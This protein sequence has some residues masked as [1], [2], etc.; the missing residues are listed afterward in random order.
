[1]DGYRV[2]K[3]CL[4]HTN[5]ECR[6]IVSITKQIV[7]WMETYIA[8]DSHAF[9]P[10]S[11][12]FLTWGKIYIVVNQWVMD[13]YNLDRVNMHMPC[14]PSYALFSRAACSTVRTAEATSLTWILLIELSPLPHVPEWPLI[15]ANSRNARSQAVVFWIPS[16]L[17]SQSCTAY[18]YVE[19]TGRYLH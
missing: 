19:I 14:A 9:V 8:Y 13:R 11:S 15:F 4:S 5:A 7:R 18:A 16:E 17:F 2:S 1:M 10:R 3:Q 12:R 6:P